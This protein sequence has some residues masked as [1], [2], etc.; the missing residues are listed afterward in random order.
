MVTSKDLDINDFEDFHEFLE[1]KRELEEQ[2]RLQFLED[3]R[4]KCYQC[5]DGNLY[6]MDYI[7]I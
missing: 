6:I 2:E 5:N 3:T 7:E 1:A 4:E